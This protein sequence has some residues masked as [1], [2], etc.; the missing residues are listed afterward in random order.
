MRRLVDEKP[1]PS[2]LPLAERSVVESQ[3]YPTSVVSLTAE[4]RDD[5]A[6]YLRTSTLFRFCSDEGIGKVLD[7]MRRENFSGGEDLLEQGHPSSR[8]FLSTKG[9]VR[10]RHLDEGLNQVE[11]IGSGWQRGMA[12][13]LS[14]LTQDHPARA[15]AFNETEGTEGTEG[16]VYILEHAELNKLIDGDP[17]FAK[18]ITQSLLKEG[19]CPRKPI[20]PLLDQEPEPYPLIGVSL[21]A[22]IESFYRSSLTAWLN[23]NLTGVPPISLFPML[24]VQIPARVLYVNGFKMTRSILQEHVNPDD[25]SNPAA[26]QLGS[27]LVPGLMM[28]PVSSLLDACNAESNTEPISRRWMRGFVPRCGREMVFGMGINQVSDAC[29]ERVTFVEDAILRTAAG[30]LLAGVVAGYFSHIPHNVAT[31]KL[32]QPHRSYQE[33]VRNM[34]DANLHRVSKDFRPNA[35]RSLAA[36]LTLVLPKGFLI[37]TAQICGSFMIINGTIHAVASNITSSRRVAPIE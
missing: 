27:A 33:I 34:V 7:H 8:V 5:V 1:P 29:A 25:Y 21:G 14:F 19:F 6:K 32:L 36:A 20:M 16:V 22:A 11:T 17:A 9:S 10:L 24:H 2:V 13:T 28:T 4:Q 12:G 30:S 37:R 26:V 3:D 15:T 31:L 18:E 23:A 35:R